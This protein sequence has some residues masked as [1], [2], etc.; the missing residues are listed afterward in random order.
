MFFFDERYIDDRYFLSDSMTKGRIVKSVFKDLS[1]GIMNLAIEHGNRHFDIY[2]EVDYPFGYSEEKFG[3]MLPV[4]FHNH[5]YIVYTEWAE[6][7]IVKGKGIRKIDFYVAKKNLDIFIELKRLTG[8]FDKESIL[9]AESYEKLVS[10]KLKGSGLLDQVYNMRFITP[11]YGEDNKVLAG[12]L[13]VNT[14]IPWSSYDEGSNDEY[15]KLF[16]PKSRQIMDEIYKVI[17]RRR[18]IHLIGNHVYVGWSSKDMKQFEENSS[19]GF[20]LPKMLSI[21]GVFCHQKG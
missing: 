6:K 17:D 15:T 18:K 8:R 21:I 11:N 13:I 20:Q 7:N 2:K 19:K 10:N 1:N 5:G 3:W 16:K 9:Y 14:T 4:F 12:I